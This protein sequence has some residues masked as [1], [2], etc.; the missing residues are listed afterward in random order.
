VMAARQD[1]IQAL[2]YE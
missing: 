2:A 1:P